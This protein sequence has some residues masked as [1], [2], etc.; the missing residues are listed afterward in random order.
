MKHCCEYIR[1]LRYKLRE[2]GIP[3]ESPA[4]VFGD[5]KSVLANASVPDSVLQKKANS[6]AY[7]FVREGSAMDEWRI[8]YINTHENIADLLTKPLGGEKRKY[9]IC[10]ILHHLYQVT[11]S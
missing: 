11:S 3:V 1:G 10:K 5:N 6:I 8:T 4:Y 9:F 2:M 7:H